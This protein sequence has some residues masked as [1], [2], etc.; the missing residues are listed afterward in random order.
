MMHKP[1]PSVNIVIALL[2]ALV[3]FGP[4]SIDMYVPGLP[5]ISAS[6]NSSPRTIQLTVT[7]FLFGF[8]IGM[9]FYGPLS[10][11]YGRRK[12]LLGGTM[13]YLLATLGCIFAQHGN[14][15]LLWRLLQAIGGAGAPVIA[16]AIVRDVFSHE[17][18]P[19]VLAHMQVITM[20]ATLAAP[21]IGGVIV[22]SLG[23]R[24][25]FVALSLFSV[26]AIL[27]YALL[28]PETYPQSNL[29][30]AQVFMA[31]WHILT[32]PSGFLYITTMGATFA[33]MFA[34]I[35]A[36]PFVYIRYF[37]LSPIAYSVLFSLNLL[38]IAVITFINAKIVTHFGPQKMI[39]Y[40]CIMGLIAGIWLAFCGVTGVGGL[41][42]IVIGVLGFVGITSV[43]GANC[44]A[45]MLRTFPEN[46]GAASGIT[47]AT[48]FAAGG[49]ASAIL[50]S[51]NSHSPLAMCLSITICSAI[52]FL[53]M[54]FANR[55][56]TS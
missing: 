21:L 37:G 9:L 13:I 12:L 36:S 5:E 16:R 15:L 32:N 14:Q 3:A 6:L 45:M 55:L 54:V 2:A 8:S 4:F 29:T 50:S 17:E 34:F 1:V 10:D 27:I 43:V 51:L 40:G 25:I 49:I 30:L 19:K 42:A 23:W 35:T 33:G 7:G 39:E 38:S 41:V 48:Q 56:T 52:A 22:S 18:S 11:R 47:T 44:I 46:A 28:M 20:L 31:Y 24:W 26:V 53:A